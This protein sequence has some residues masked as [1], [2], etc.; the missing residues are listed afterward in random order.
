MS[1]DAKIQELIDERASAWEAAKHYWESE[2]ETLEAAD[3]EAAAR[4]SAEITDLDKRIDELHRLNEANKKSEAYRA[5]YE[6]L[7]R[8]DVRDAHETNQA[9][10]LLAFLRG[11]PGNAGRN[12]FD[13][14]FS[15]RSVQIDPKTF[16]WNIRDDRAL[17]SNVA[18]SGGATVPDSFV[19]ELYQHMIENSAIRQTNVRVVTTSSGEPLE[20]PKT[21]THGTATLVGEGTA[22]AGSDPS[23]GSVTLNSWRY[24]QLVL[25]SNELVQDER[26][27]LLSYLAQDMGRAIGNASGAAFIT[28]SGTNAPNGVVTA[29][30]AQVGTAVQV[31]SATVEGD[32]L[33]D[34]Q[35]SVIEP[36]ASR[37]FWMMARGTEGKIRKA[38]APSGDYLWEPS[39]QVGVPNQLLG[40]PIVTDPNM[41]AVASAAMSVIFGDFNAYVIRD[42][43]GI[44]LERSDDFKFDTYQTAFRAVLRTDGDLLDGSGAIKGLDTD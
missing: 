8:P 12:A 30:K 32:N 16:E 21:I 41:A 24:G 27:N 39:F 4:A 43:A 14:D 42:V 31:A 22:I 37:G 25:L 1:M 33:I 11:G 2:D 10:G 15:G 28:G 7:V 34:L 18:L 44:R 35:Y 23:F 26:V 9:E 38:K 17:V 19:N 6:S 3:A 40:R 29:T 13:I 20:F 36:Y 5:Q